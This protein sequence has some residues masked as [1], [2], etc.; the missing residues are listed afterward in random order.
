MLTSISF[1][2]FILNILVLIVSVAGFLKVIKNDLTHV[3]KYLDEIK[4]KLSDMDAKL[5]NNSERIASIE[6]KCSATHG[7]N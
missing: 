5:D 2:S 7:E 3:Q 4:N 1:W 6:G